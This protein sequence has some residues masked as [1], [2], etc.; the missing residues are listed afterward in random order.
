ML[1]HDMARHSQ[2]VEALHTSA[3]SKITVSPVQMAASLSSALLS[4]GLVRK[5][6]VHPKT[7]LSH[8]VLGENDDLDRLSYD[9]TTATSV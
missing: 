6:L 3:D 7:G 2:H 4:P 9:S 5:W 8:A 1:F